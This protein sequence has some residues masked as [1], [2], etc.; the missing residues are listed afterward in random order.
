[1]SLL[2]NL[3]S[4][5]WP[6]AKFMACVACATYSYTLVDIT[7][8]LRIRLMYLCHSFVRPCSQLLCSVYMA[9]ADMC[10]H[11][12][13][14]RCM[15]SQSATRNAWFCNPS[16]STGTE[17]HD[18]S[19]ALTFCSCHMQV[20]DRLMTHTHSLLTRILQLT[21]EVVP[22]G[23]PARARTADVLASLACTV[24]LSVTAS[25]KRHTHSRV[26]HAP[27]VRTAA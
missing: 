22:E 7:R 25:A 13:H 1:M 15:T 2:V 19:G 10:P 21:T 6:N 3:P 24:S 17:S 8:R 14:A 16:I 20:Q 18:T 11:F 27:C 9:D 12:S 26:A 23:Q 5:R 4:W